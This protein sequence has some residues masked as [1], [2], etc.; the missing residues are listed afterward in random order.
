MPILS[1]GPHPNLTP[2]RC[3]SA[4]PT[5]YAPGGI[6]L[7]IHN[8]RAQGSYIRGTNGASNGILPMLR[9]FNDTAR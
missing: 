1:C 9:V 7:S 6:G 5:A 3:P 8:I 4:S 2:L